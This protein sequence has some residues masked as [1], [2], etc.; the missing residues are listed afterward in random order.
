MT[1]ADY[2][3]NKLCYSFVTDKDLGEYKQRKIL[4]SALVWGCRVAV[5]AQGLPSAKAVYPVDSDPVIQGEQDENHVTIRN[6]KAK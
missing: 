5:K 4:L 2:N 3:F 1:L 6:R